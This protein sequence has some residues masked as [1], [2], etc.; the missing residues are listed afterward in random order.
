MH[1][2]VCCMHSFMYGTTIQGLWL[3]G[4]EACGR[5]FISLAVRLASFHKSSAAEI[6]IPVV[7]TKRVLEPVALEPR[8][9]L[10]VCN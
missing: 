5:G 9:K 8:G 1:P 6:P 3:A 2:L 7:Q 10:A 4:R